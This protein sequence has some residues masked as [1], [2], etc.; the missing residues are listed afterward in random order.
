MAEHNQSEFEQ[1]EFEFLKGSPAFDGLSDQ[2]IRSILAKARPMEVRSGEVLFRQGDPGGTMYVITSGRVRVLLEDD[3][4]E[5]SLLNVLDRGAHFGEL[6]MLIGSPRNATI[7]AVVDTDLLVLNHDHFA[8]AV[9]QVPQFAVN[10]SKTLGRWLRGELLGTRRQ[11]IRAVFAVIRTRK[12]HAVLAPQMVKAFKDRGATVKVVTDR[13]QMWAADD[14]LAELVH[15]NDLEPLRDRVADA[16]T[17]GVRVLVDCD[18]ETAEPSL[19]SQCEHLLWLFDNQDQGLV[20]SRLGTFVR[21]RNHLAGHSQV[22]WTHERSVRLPRHASHDLPLP[23]SDMR[24]QWEHASGEPSFRKH[25]VTRCVHCV[26]DLQF[27]LALGGGGAKGVAHLGVIEVLNRE[28]IYFDSVA[29]TSAGA[30][31]SAGYA[32]GKSPE[33]L[34][35]LMLKEMTPPTWLRKIPKSREMFLLSQFRMGWIE[36]KFREHLQNVQFDE[37]LLP[38]SLVTVDLVTG[39]ERIRRSG[40]VVSS[41]MESINHPI[42]G[43]PILRGNE[44]LVDGGVLANVPSHC[45]R[46]Q[47]A[48]FVLAVDVTTKLSTDFCRDPRRPDALTS[49]GYLRTLLRVNDVSLRSLS[50]IHRSGSDYVITPDTSAHTFDDFAAGEELMDLGRAAAEAALPEIKER[51]AKVYRSIDDNA[52]R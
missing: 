6:S 29:G 24:V 22:V 37:L 10:L 4:G 5:Q 11:V 16:V 20:E 49:P 48:N 46:R 8:E 39:Q 38:A 19:L 9:E 36:P 47:G 14:I 13:P 1:S 27:G 28:G 42:F 7:K 25:D 51:V 32:M 35:Q 30:I 45:L 44:A 18:V 26:D 52:S 2:D 41:V 33:V 15:G 31:M 17:Q 40:D 50:G 12:E 23:G 3:T 43:K 34:L 21:D